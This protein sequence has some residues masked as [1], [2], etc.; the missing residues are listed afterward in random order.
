MEFNFPF[1]WLEKH[2]SSKVRELVQIP[3]MLCTPVSCS[4]TMQTL[5]MQPGLL[6]LLSHSDPLSLSLSDCLTPRLSRPSRRAQ[7]I[8]F[9]EN[10]WVGRGGGMWAGKEPSHTA[11]WVLGLKASRTNKVARV[12][13]KKVPVSST[14]FIH[15][16]RAGY[17][18]KAGMNGSHQAFFLIYLP[19]PILS[20]P[21]PPEEALF[22]CLSGFVSLCSSILFGDTRRDIAAW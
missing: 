9:G 4:E 1:L 11:L 13:S 7:S 20:R 19:R 8:E 3:C 17:G 22:S 14:H 6:R 16:G 2:K 15:R 12:G 18:D 5:G 10:D 21:L